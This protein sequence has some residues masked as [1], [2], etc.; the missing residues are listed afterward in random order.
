M[1]RICAH[2]L[3][4]FS[5]SNEIIKCL[6]RN[7]LGCQAVMATI[8]FLYASGYCKTAAAISLNT[9]KGGR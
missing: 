3:N 1:K 5:I 4:N 7:V 8:D 6:E 2:K 9:F